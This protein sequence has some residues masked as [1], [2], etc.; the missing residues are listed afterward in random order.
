MD[1]EYAVVF[2]AH[3]RADLLAVRRW[4]NQPGSGLRARLRLAKISRAL[5]ELR[6]APHRWPIGDHPGV[7]ERAVEGHR[8]F[9][10][11]DEVQRTVNVLRVFGPFQNR[12]P[13]S[14]KRQ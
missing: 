10:R 2:A 3:G 1:T 6:F 12:A 14:S 11:V 5:T 4:L 9:Y 13:S 8:I 7:R